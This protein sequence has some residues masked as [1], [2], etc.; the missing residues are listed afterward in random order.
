MSRLILSRGEN[1]WFAKPQTCS[2]PCQYTTPACFVHPLW[3][4]RAKANTE[5]ELLHRHG[6][7]PLSALIISYGID[8]STHNLESFLNCRKSLVCKHLRLRGGRPVVVKSSPA[9]PYGVA[10][11]SPRGALP[12][13]LSTMGSQ[14]F[15]G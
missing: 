2:V 9:T 10:G 12:H 4:G 15:Q 14:L 13:T 8:M 11:L 3:W 6:F 5:Q 1:E 7:I